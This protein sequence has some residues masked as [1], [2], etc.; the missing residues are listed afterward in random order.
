MKDENNPTGNEKMEE[1]GL[2]SEWKVKEVVSD[3][4]LCKKISDK[5]GY[6]V[7][8]ISEMLRYSII[9]AQQLSEICCV[10]YSTIINAIKPKLRKTEITTILN[11]TKPFLQNRTKGPIFIVRDEKCINFISKHIFI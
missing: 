8:V 6:S 3:L 11:Y 1:V 4:L 5:T 10:D 7:E 9:T 2:I